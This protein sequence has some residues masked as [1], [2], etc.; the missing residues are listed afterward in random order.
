MPVT[1]AATDSFLYFSDLILL[2][3]ITP[4][5]IKIVEGFKSSYVNPIHHKCALI[6]YIYQRRRISRE[7]GFGFSSNFVLSMGIVD[8]V[9]IRIIGLDSDIFIPELSFYGNIYSIISLIIDHYNHYINTIYRRNHES[10]SI[11]YKNT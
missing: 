7:Y 4:L 6:I 5:N 11:N 2:F 10:N 8:E 3:M 9:Q 1:K